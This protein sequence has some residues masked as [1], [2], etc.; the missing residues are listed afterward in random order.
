MA[1]TDLV[2]GLTS[3]LSNL[4]PS[5]GPPQWGRVSWGM[6]RDAVATRYPSAVESS[7]DLVLSSTAGEAGRPYT[8]TLGFNATHQ[9]ETVTL[10]FAGSSETADF[11][12]MAQRITRQLGSAPVEQTWDSMTWQ[13]GDEEMT[14]T[15][16][17]GGGVV[18]SQSA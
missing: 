18:F 16:S 7:G 1:A 10:N 3:L 4:N 13:R 8:M 5:S 9:L 6:S 14:L 11:A 2:Q 12:A 15:K 17:P